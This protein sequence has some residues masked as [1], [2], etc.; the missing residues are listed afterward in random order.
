MVK[1]DEKE[2]N[3]IFQIAINKDGV[4]RGNYHNEMTDTTLPIYGSVDKESQRAAW[5]V[6]DKK[7][8]VYEAGLGNLS[9]P[10]TSVLIHKGKERTQQWLL[11]RLDPPPEEK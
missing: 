4:L 2:A 3:N 7:D 11:V 9:Q 5:T 1:G 10:E 6:G 8:T